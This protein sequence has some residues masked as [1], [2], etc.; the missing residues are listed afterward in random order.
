MKREPTL[1]ELIDE[2]AKHP[3]VDADSRKLHETVMRLGKGIL[4]A[5][6]E[7]IKKQSS[8]LPD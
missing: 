4:H 5:W 3:P 2:L 8:K 6:D 7:W 1:S